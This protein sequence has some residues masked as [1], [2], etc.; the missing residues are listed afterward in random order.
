MPLR[1]D[2]PSSYNIPE[3]FENEIQH[4]QVNIIIKI[5]LHLRKKIN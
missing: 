4:W 1:V 2:I 3:R 5:R